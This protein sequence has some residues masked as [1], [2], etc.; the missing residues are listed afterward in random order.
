MLNEL[1]PIIGLMSELRLPVLRATPVFVDSQSMLFIANDQ[2][3]VK[4]SVWILRRAAVLREFVDQ[5]VVE[6]FKVGDPDNVANM[7]TKPLTL[8][9]LNRCLEYLKPA[10]SGAYLSDIK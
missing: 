2:A 4:R 1:V 6:F 3:A 5:Q 10:S 8:A 9:A 7:L